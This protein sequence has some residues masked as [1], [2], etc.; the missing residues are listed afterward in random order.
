MFPTSSLCFPLVLKARA[1][2]L[3]GSN[4][5]EVTLDKVEL[6]PLD[7]DKYQEAVAPGPKEKQPVPRARGDG[8]ARS[9]SWAKKLQ[10]E[11]HIQQLKMEQGLPGAASQLA[12]EGQAKA[13]VKAEAKPK[14][15]PKGVALKSPKTPKTKAATVWGQSS[16]SPHSKARVVEAKGAAELKRPK[17]LPKDKSNQQVLQQT[18]QSNLECFLFLQQA[19]EA[20]QYLGMCH[21]SPVKRKVLDVG[22]YNIVMRGWARKVPSSGCCGWDRGWLLSEGLRLGLPVLVTGVRAVPVPRGQSW[23]EATH[24]REV[25]MKG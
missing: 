6:A 13:G 5:P 12:L 21:S 14:A 4:V 15:K 7:N 3:Q 22:T 1:K 2:Q 19:E 8:L 16:S 20:E 9:S 11:M 25:V 23:H 17:R 10:K 24:G 18:I